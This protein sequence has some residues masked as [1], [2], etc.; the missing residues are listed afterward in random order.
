MSADER[1]RK[2]VMLIAGIL[3]PI[4]ERNLMA[5]AARF[6]YLGSVR[7][8]VRELLKTGEL[9]S[10]TVDGIHYLMPHSQKASAEP[11]RTVRFLAPF[12]PVVWDRKR[13]EHFWGWPYRFEAYTPPAKRVRGYY[14]LPLL[15][16]DAVIGWANAR[17][18]DDRLKVEVGFANRAPAAADFSRELQA[19]IARLE[20]FLAL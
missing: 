11:P 18:H 16:C 17:V 20:T 7:P 10:Q 9:E 8:V 5:N 14:A 6:R 3:A 4:S 19:E 1:L 15:W 13:F 12:D 2:L